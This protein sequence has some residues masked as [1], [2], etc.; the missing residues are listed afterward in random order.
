MSQTQQIPEISP[1]LQIL[2]RPENDKSGDQ[3]IIPDLFIRSSKAFSPLHEVNVIGNLQL[4]I[5][6]HRPFGAWRQEFRRRILLIR[7]AIVSPSR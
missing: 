6:H 2:E 1:G 3:H 5:L 7:R 4:S